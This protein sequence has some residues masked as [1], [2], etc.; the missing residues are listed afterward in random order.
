ME[1]QELKIGS[2]YWIELK[3]VIASEHS[4]NRWLIGQW[5]GGYWSVCGTIYQYP[6]SRIKSI[7]SEVIREDC[8]EKEKE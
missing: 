4:A 7:G 2:W 3:E 5:R 1:N 8:P 6:P